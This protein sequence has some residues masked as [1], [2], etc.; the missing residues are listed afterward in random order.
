MDDSGTIIPY[1]VTRK[2]FRTGS[3]FVDF[4]YRTAFGND[5]QMAY[6][7]EKAKGIFLVK[8]CTN[9]PDKCFA[10][11]PN[12]FLNPKICENEFKSFYHPIPKLR[13]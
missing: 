13:Q 7:F 3:T 10:I 11:F 9:K 5:N 1:N 6:F 12:S 4:Y 2:F 8:M